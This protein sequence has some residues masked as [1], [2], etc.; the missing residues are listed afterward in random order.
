MSLTQFPIKALCAFILMGV[1]ASCTTSTIPLP[2]P[3][4]RNLTGDTATVEFGNVIVDSVA[5]RYI[6]FTN[7]G[8]DTL[9]IDAIWATHV[10]YDTN[11]KAGNFAAQDSL[12][13]TLPI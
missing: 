5:H 1:L 9:H 2:P 4:T 13:R 10:A 12:N 6:A 8:N 7:T 3:I 11:D